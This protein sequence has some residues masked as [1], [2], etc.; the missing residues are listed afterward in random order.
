MS[1]WRHE[2]AFCS[3]LGLCP[4]NKKSGGKI[5]GSRTRKVLSRA[6]TAFG[7]AAQSLGRTESCPGI[8]YRRKKAHLGAPM[9]TTAMAHKLACIVYAMPKHRE[10]YQAPD[11]IAYQQKLDQRRLTNLCKQ[12]ASLGYQLTELMPVAAQVP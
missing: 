9:A 6:A 12:A 7:L 10:A 4:G 3:W 8:F 11:P 1:R 2:K 5:P